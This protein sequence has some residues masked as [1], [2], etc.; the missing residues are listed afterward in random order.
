MDQKK[1]VVS[2]RK[3]ISGRFVI[4]KAIENKKGILGGTILVFEI[5]C[6]KSK[7]KKR[8]SKSL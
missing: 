1:R 8:G 3:T 6:G 2:Q 5:V 7:E 4:V